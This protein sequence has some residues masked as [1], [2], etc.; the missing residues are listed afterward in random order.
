[1]AGET[2]S[3]DGAGEPCCKVQSAAYVSRPPG[4]GVR[5]ASPLHRASDA[6][7]PGPSCNAH[8]P[9]TNSMNWGLP[10]AEKGSTMRLSIVLLAGLT[11]LAAWFAAADRATARQDGASVN[12]VEVLTRGPVHEA[13][14]EPI[15]PQPRPTPVVPQQPPEPVPE[16][17]PDTRPEGENF[18]WIPGYWAW[19]DESRG[20]L[21]VSGLWRDAPPDRR[22]VSGYWQQVEGGWQRVPG[23]WGAETIAEVEYLPVPPDPVPEAVPPAPDHSS[24]FVPGVWTW[25]ESNYYWRPG[26]YTAYQ[27]DW[28]YSPAHYMYTPNGYLFVDG[29]WDHP[30]HR[31]GY[32]SLQC[33]SARGAGRRQLELRAAIR[34]VPGRA[35][36]IPVRSPGG[37]QLLLRRLFWR[38]NMRAAATRRGSTTV[39]AERP[40]I[41][42]S[43]TTARLTAPTRTG[44]G[45]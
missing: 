2:V 27:P 15:D 5:P 12:G 32:C 33:A 40:T 44:R 16:L 28:T 8:E 25:R 26:F 21:W 13:F 9:L 35:D 31:R 24:I 6:L 34:P 11:G 3:R 14:A 43:L 37:V 23:F 39:W 19:D 4:F 42:I 10:V 38:F 41:R 30:L 18:Q 29:F 45:A 1:M 20:F 36:D 17:P 22:W 7:R